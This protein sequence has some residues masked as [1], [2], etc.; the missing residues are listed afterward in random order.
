MNSKRRAL[1]AALLAMLLV[2]AACGSSSKSSKTGGGTS[3]TA[4]AGSDL[5]GPAE[6]LQEIGIEARVGQL[7]GAG[8]RRQPVEL[9]I[10]AGHLVDR[11][12]Q[13]FGP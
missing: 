7:H 3:T 5:L 6:D 8:A 9:L 12:E 1:G 2:A 4:G 10:D 11:I 13:R